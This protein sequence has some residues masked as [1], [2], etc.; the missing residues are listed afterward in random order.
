[1][2]S[3][4]VH[5]RMIVFPPQT[6]CQRSVVFLASL[7]GPLCLTYPY[8]LNFYLLV[9]FKM[10]YCQRFLHIVIKLVFI[11]KKLG[12]ERPLGIIFYFLVNLVR[13]EE[14]ELCAF[15]RL[16]GDFEIRDEKHYCKKES[17]TETNKNCYSNICR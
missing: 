16:E 3:A 17:A 14:S 4:F 15:I 1:M 5:I 12:K 2:V 9:K 6:R 10:L 13:R 7:L 8:F 11:K